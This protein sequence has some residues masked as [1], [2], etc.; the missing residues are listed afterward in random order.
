M[1]RIEAKFRELAGQDKTAFIPYIAAGDPDLEVTRDLIKE[2]EAAG[3]DMIELGV[4]YS[5]PLADGPTIQQASQRALKNG[6]TIDQIFDL[7]K[8]VRTET[9]IPIILMGYYNSF[10][11]YGFKKIISRAEEAAVDGLIIPDL[12]PEEGKEINNLKQDDQVANIFLLTPTSSEQRIK[13]ID[14][15]SEGFI[16]CVALTGVTGARDSLAPDLKEFLTKVRNYSDQ[17]LGVGFGIS[18]PR[19]A[20]KVAEDADAVI[21]GSAIIRKMEE[22]LDLLPGKKQE[23]VSKVGDF[24]SNLSGAL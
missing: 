3:A 5:D 16:Y 12:P 4:P 9:E 18:T 13:L 20:A 19:Q 7:V 23:F 2:L 22:N 11:K 17:P 24:V 6:I 21:V 8:E 1:N 15:V 10:Y 14:E